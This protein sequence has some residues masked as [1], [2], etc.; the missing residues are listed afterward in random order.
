MDAAAKVM[1]SLG[2]ARATAEQIASTA[3]WGFHLAMKVA[4]Q[5]CG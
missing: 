1:E 5:T 3:G 4:T 2:L